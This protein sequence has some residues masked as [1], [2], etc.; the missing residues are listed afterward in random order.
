MISDDNVKGARHV[1]K[2]TLA[3]EFVLE[4]K[5]EDVSLELLWKPLL[6]MKSE[7]FLSIII[8]LLVLII[9]IV[10]KKFNSNQV[11]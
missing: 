1:D 7:G 4:N 5:D 8:Y 11:M 2:L 9:V 6:C 3:Y 10:S